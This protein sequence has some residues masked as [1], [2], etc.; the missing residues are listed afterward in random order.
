MDGIEISLINQEPRV[1]SRLIA[2]RMGVDHRVT[3]RL[4]GKFKEQF[5]E[6]GK[7]CF[8]NAPSASGQIQKFVALNEDQSVFLLTLT[9]NSPDAVP[10]KVELTKAFARYRKAFNRQAE[11]RAALDWQQ[12]RQEGKT[13]RRELEAVLAAFVAY[14]RRRG[15]R[16]PET[17]FVNVTRMVYRTF[18]NLSPEIERQLHH[19]IREHLDVRQLQD[20]NAVEGR[21]ALNLGDGMAQGVDYKAIFA[22]AKALVVELARIFKP[23]PVLP[24]A[25]GVDLDAR[26]KTKSL[27]AAVQ[28]PLWEPRA[29]QA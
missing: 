10:L 7:V 15:C 19:T 4:I 16:H 18:F 23:A 20:L 9:R 12:A 6:F 8:Q 27:R 2:K 17:Y 5:A 26:G 24:V 28:L 3:Y 22:A 11:R 21:L 29:G 13:T 25:I 1:D 14:A